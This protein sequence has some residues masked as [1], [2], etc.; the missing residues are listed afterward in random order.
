MGKSESGSKSKPQKA[1]SA[2]KTLLKTN[3]E[4]R[5]LK[6]LREFPLVIKIC[7]KGLEP[8]P[9]IPYLQ[10]LAASFHSF[11]NKHRVVTDNLA[12]TQARLELIN[13]ARIIL[14]TGLKLLGISTPTKM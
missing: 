9:L 6:T 2:D 3:E 1:I 10:D 13:C 8:Y 11:Y 7:A 14:A 4:F 12:L 5:I